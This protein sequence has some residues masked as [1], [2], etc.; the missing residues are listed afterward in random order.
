MIKLTITESKSD[1][2]YYA[3]MSVR[4]GKKVRSET[5]KKI[6]KHSELLKITDDPEAY[7]NAIVEQ[8]DDEYRKAKAPLVYNVDF[9]KKIDESAATVSQSTVRNTG[10]FFLQYILNRLNLRKYLSALTTDSKISYTFST[11][12]SAGLMVDQRFQPIFC[13]ST[14]ENRII[15]FVG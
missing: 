14:V 11:V 9:S 4:N 12:K 15:S 1:K 8:L 3:Q 7:A 6:G 10:Y 13:F 2:Y 5:I